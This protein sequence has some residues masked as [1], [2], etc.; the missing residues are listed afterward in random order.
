MHHLFF[1]QGNNPS[2]LGIQAFDAVASIEE[3][4]SLP[5]FE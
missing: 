2:M 3:N 4:N 5:F 1:R